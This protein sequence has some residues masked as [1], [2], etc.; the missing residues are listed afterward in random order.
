MLGLGSFIDVAGN[1]FA[2][3]LDNS[4]PFITYENSPVYLPDLIEGS[5]GE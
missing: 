4:F 5:E 1:D 3:A 2:D